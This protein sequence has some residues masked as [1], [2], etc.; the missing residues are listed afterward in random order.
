[1][2]YQNRI[3]RHFKLYNIIPADGWNVCITKM[4]PMPSLTR[5]P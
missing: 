4:R 3:G 5:M 2:I 1:M